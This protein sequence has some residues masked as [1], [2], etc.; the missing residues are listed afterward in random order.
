LRLLLLLLVSPVLLLRRRSSCCCCCLELNDG[1]VKAH[2][3]CSQHCASIE[4]CDAFVNQ[5]SLLGA[6]TSIE[7]SRV[8]VSDDIATAAAATAGGIAASASSSGGSFIEKI[9]NVLPRNTDG[10]SLLWSARLRLGLLGLLLLL[11]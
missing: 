8:E 5:G 7:A 4:G 10:V 9:V 3:R 2:T 6:Y 11:L 1:S